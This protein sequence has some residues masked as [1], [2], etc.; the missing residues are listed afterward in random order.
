MPAWF[1]VLRYVYQHGKW[2]PG[3]TC[4]PRLIS[5]CAT[6]DARAGSVLA[7]A[8]ADLGRAATAPV[9]LTRCC[10]CTDPSTWVGWARGM[11]RLGGAAP[12]TGTP[13]PTGARKS[14][15]GPKRLFRG[16]RCRI[17]PCGGDQGRSGHLLGSLRCVGSL[18]MSFENSPKLRPRCG[19]AALASIVGQGGCGMELALRFGISRGG[20]AGPL[21]ALLAGG[22]QLPGSMRHLPFGSR[23]ICI[24]LSGPG[25]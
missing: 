13:T 8:G 21:Q 23:G 19:S 12:Y 10:R 22:S 7:R 25:R 9:G 2:V 15:M 17:R 4:S 11:P 20:G 18:G 14:K 24:P 3:S 1:P 6:G 5:A 16:F